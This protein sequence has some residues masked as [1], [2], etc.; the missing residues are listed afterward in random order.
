MSEGTL[1]TIRL[2]VALHNYVNAEDPRKLF[3]NL[4]TIFASYFLP[5][6]W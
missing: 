5:A 1:F 2:Q 6:R 4:E 3:T